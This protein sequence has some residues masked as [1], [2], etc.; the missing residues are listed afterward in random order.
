M[1]PACVTNIV[2]GY[3][4][5]IPPESNAHLPKRCRNM[6]TVVHYCISS[7]DRTNSGPRSFLRSFR[8][9]DSRNQNESKNVTTA[10]FCIVVDSNDGP[11]MVILM[12]V[13]K[14]SG[15]S[16]HLFVL[17]VVIVIVIV[18]FAVV[19]LLFDCCFCWLVLFVRIVRTIVR[20]LNRSS[21]NQHQLFPSHPSSAC[22]L[23]LQSFVASI[24]CCFQLVCGFQRCHHG[25]TVVSKPWCCSRRWWCVRFVV[26]EN[27]TAYLYI[28]F[29][30]CRSLA[31][32]GLHPISCLRKMFVCT[33]SVLTHFLFFT[34]K[35]Q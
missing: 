22:F 17:F 1:R 10:L 21:D 6:C 11:P 2:E 23:H 15:A 8:T 5:S 26:T 3:G 9:L 12:G 16:L 7:T 25:G 24:V 29:C 31:N 20:I 27:S 28:G 35:L 33:I 14:V 32:T 30:T 34:E 13:H 18:L 19:L 4:K